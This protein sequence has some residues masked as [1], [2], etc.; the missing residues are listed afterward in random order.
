MTFISSQGP[1]D[2]VA[3][4]AAIVRRNTEAPSPQSSLGFIPWQL[5]CFPEPAASLVTLTCHG[6]VDNRGVTASRCLEVRNFPMEEAVSSQ[7]WHSRYRWTFATFSSL[8][9]LGSVV[10]SD[11]PKTPLTLLVR[12]AGGVEGRFST[13]KFAWLDSS[14]T[15]KGSV[16]LLGHTLSGFPFFPLWDATCRVVWKLGSSYGTSCLAS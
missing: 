3:H 1:L 11:S 16:G 13:C 5:T 12:W 4:V 6:S 8:S 2:G 7:P 9:G 10:G 14:Q 15:G